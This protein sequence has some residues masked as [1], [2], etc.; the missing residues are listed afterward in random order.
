MFNTIFRKLVA[1]LLLFGLLMSLIFLMIMRYSHDVYHQESQQKFHAGMA[2]RF[3]VLAGWTA[4]GWADPRAVTNAFA[5]LVAANPQFHVFILDQE[6]LVLSHYPDTMRLNSNHISVQPIERMLQTAAQLPILGEDPVGTRSPEI[7]SVTQLQ[8]NNRPER[9]L[10]V[11][12]H[13]EEHDESAEGLRLSYVTREGIWLIVASLMLAFTGG[14]LSLHFVVRPLK[15]LASTMDGFREN[16]FKGDVSG[17]NK[18]VPSGDEIDTLT[19]TFYRMAEQMQTQMREIGE[20]DASRR[21]FIANVS[22]DLRTP[23][24]SIQGYLDTLLLKNGALTAQERQQY[25]NIALNQAESLSRL[26]TTLFYLAKLDSGQIA[27]QPER[28]RIDEVVQDVVQKFAIDAQTKH[29]RVFTEAHGK[30]PFVCADLGLI[31]RVLSN[32]I[33]NALRHTPEGGSVRIHLQHTHEKVWISVIDSGS[34]ISAADLPHV[35]ERFYRGNRARD[36]SAH[37]A[38]LGLSIVH[39]IVDMHGEVVEAA[40]DQQHGALFRL[41]L[42]SADSG[43][44]PCTREQF[45]L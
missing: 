7:F 1:V 30:L 4:S 12:L 18:P 24:A 27:L 33:D 14:L 26:I 16:H 45:P 20:A 40:N 5:K 8:G 39:R 15:Q 23:L 10:Y 28:F 41:S 35:F 38:G 11:T 37:N 21:E 9:Y 44:T 13:S 43:D 2:T 3:A 32:L 19:A 36:E 25:L 29:I 17:N 6:G 31:E 34:G 22:H 42:S